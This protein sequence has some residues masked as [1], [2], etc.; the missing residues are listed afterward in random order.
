MAFQTRTT[1]ERYN[2]VALE[3]TNSYAAIPGQGHCSRPCEKLQAAGSPSTACP[4]LYG[5]MLPAKLTIGTWDIPALAGLQDFLRL[6]SSHVA[7]ALWQG[8]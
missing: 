6:R 7:H 8:L 3:R 2:T 4:S 5:Y 1:V